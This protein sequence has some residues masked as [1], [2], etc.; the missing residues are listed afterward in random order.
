M[1]FERAQ[2]QLSIY[3]IMKKYYGMLPNYYHHTTLRA[4]HAYFHSR[5]KQIA[6][7]MCKINCSLDIKRFVSYYFI[8]LEVGRTTLM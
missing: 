5:M 7:N 4:T 8:I 6:Q 2:L 1:E 3:S